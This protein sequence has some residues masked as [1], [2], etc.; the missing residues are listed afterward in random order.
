MEKVSERRDDAVVD[1]GLIEAETKGSVGLIED[2]AG[3]QQP[4]MGLSDD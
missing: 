1:L 3:L 4:F 2:T